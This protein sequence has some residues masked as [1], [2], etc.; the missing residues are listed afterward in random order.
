M[1]P[2]DNR[3]II[4]IC[5]LAAFSVLVLSILSY[6]SKLVEKGYCVFA[7]TDGNLTECAGASCDQCLQQQR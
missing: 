6:N 1:S 3:N 4:A 2:W 7:Y 5:L